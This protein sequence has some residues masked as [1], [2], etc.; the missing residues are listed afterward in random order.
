MAQCC[1]VGILHPHNFR[2]ERTVTS[3]GWAPYLG[4]FIAL[5]IQ[6]YF[7]DS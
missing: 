7:Y 3:A 6:T 5:N 4:L 2:L 1:A